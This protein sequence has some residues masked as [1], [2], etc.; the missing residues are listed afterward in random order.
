MITWAIL[1]IF[2]G[3]PLIFC[4]LTVPACLFCLFSIIYFSF[5]AK[6]V[7]IMRTKPNQALVAEWY[8]PLLMRLK[9]SELNFEIFL[10]ESPYDKD[11]SLK[12]RF[13]K[14]VIGTVSVKDHQSIYNAAFIYRFAINPKYSFLKVGE[15]LIK[16]VAKNS[17]KNGYATLE[18]AISEWQEDERDF[19]DFMG[20]ATRQIYHKQIIG[21][22]L[23]VMKSNLTYEL[24]TDESLQ[25]QN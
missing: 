5:Y 21:N 10:N 12:N 15:Q 24:N 8:E 14:K 4:A 22:T 20:F 25:K 7:E 3:V 6:A 18:C 16:M 9:P 19:Y 13:R 11:P 2:F 17:G 23:C 1:F